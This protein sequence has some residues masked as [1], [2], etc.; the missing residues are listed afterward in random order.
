MQT[1]ILEN[2]T[3]HNEQKQHLFKM[4]TW[5]AHT[6]EP[7]IE[8][9]TLEFCNKNIRCKLFSLS[10]N[11][12]QI[13]KGEEFFVTKVRLPQYK[14][15]HTNCEI[16]FK[17]SKETIESLLNKILGDL[18]KKFSFNDLT[19]LEAKVLTKLNNNVCKSFE[20]ILLNT[21]A[22]ES[23]NYYN[24]HFFL[25]LDNEILGKYI[26]SIP[27]KLIVP[28]EIQIQAYNIDLKD[29]INTT[30]K[31]NIIVG[32]SKTT[33]KDLKRLEKEDIVI[34]DN[35]KLNQMTLFFNEEY[36]NIK[37]NP[38]PAIMIDLDCENEENF[39]NDNT[40]KNMWD[41]I[42][43]EIG[44]EFEKVKLTLG[45]LKQI[46]EGL[47]IDLAS[48]YKNKIA[49]KVEN[50][51]IATGELVIIDDRYGVKIEKVYESKEQH[52]DNINEESEFIDDDMDTQDELRED[53]D[54]NENDE[55]FDYSD[56]DVD[57]DGDI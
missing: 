42:Q 28:Q 46:S 18:G 6:F 47:V 43:V 40:D 13:F 50:K 31:V 4:F 52:Q 24:L 51:V 8:E 23:D 48:V 1:E 45:E 10:N 14:K 12:T 56:F 55:D 57:D 21:P 37:V 32:K 39:M 19:N 30:T 44:A 38:D 5:F 27:Q 17:L 36:R 15:I 26:V 49:L 16:F 33:L 25:K 3:F 41:N 2:E 53:I 22:S 7:L 29:F 11:S 35:S 54:E 34:L 20:A 9:K